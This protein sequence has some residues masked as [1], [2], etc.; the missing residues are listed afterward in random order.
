MTD[1]YSLDADDA[2]AEGY[3]AGKQGQS[4]RLCPYPYLTKMRT[5]WLDGYRLAVNPPIPSANKRDFRTA[6]AS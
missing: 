5:A 3:L 1:I 2:H 4:F 6:V